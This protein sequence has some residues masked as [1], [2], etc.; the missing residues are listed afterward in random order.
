MVRLAACRG[1]RLRSGG[2][3]GKASSVKHLLGA[4]LCLAAL[5]TP[6]CSQGTDPSLQAW[7]SADEPTRT[8]A[9]SL[10]RRAFDSYVT[11]R[12]MIEPPQPVPSLLKQRIGVFVST[13][14]GGAPRCCM[15]TIYPTESNAAR[16]I[17]SSAVAAAGR[18]RRFP[19]VKQAELKSLILIVSV[20]AK[21][22][23]ITM[24][25]LEILDPTRD[26]LLV[27]AGGR[28]GV[29]LSGETD[30]TDRMLKWGRIRAGVGEKAAVELFRLDVVRFVEG[31]PAQ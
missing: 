28:M 5:G 7:R 11:R 31:R 30:R 24:N 1:M 13:M 6:A 14:R 8:Y 3:E 15:G 17:V 21:P 26:G 10:A 20:I 2:P 22:R 18:D 25:E 19:P 12:A 9:L 27:K 4:A 23:P 16:E 29:V